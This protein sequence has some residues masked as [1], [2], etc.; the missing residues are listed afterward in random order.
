MRRRVR[1]RSL[2]AALALALAGAAA[3][4]G[5]HGD[6]ALRDP[7]ATSPGAARELVV[8]A[9]SELVHAGAGHTIQ[10][11]APSLVV[12][13]D[14]TPVLG[15]ARQDEGGRSVSVVRVEDAGFV[16]TR[17]DSAALPADAVH[18]PP[19]LALGTDG[20]LL[21]TWSAA[22]A[23]PEGVLFASDLE[24]SR[25][26]D[27]GRSFAPPLRVNDDRPISHSF[28]AVAALADGGALVAWI[29]SREGWEK[30]RTYVARFA[31]EGDALR[32][33]DER[34]LPGDTCVCC[35]VA[36]ASGAEG[37]VGLLWRD[38]FPGSVRDMVLAYAADG[39][40]R[41]GSR[42]R[43][44]EDA[45]S[46]EACPHRGGALAFDARGRAHVAWYTEGTDARPSVRYARRAA[47]GTFS[48]PLELAAGGESV[49]DHVALAATPDGRVVVVYEA[50]TAVRRWIVARA[51]ADGGA[52]FGPPQ[53]L[54]KAL[55]AY[56]PAVAAAP[57]GDFVVAWHEDAF[58]VRRSVVLRVAVP[59]R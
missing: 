55:K 7:R 24:L 19:G 1:A 51:S 2:G 32:R 11:S 36:A 48:E 40:G 50:V 41:F 20:A 18:Q 12:L 53:V 15:L 43:V 16:W 21:V 10:L 17:V 14:G 26:R 42:A 46:L 49:P 45:W 27:G 54:S 58:P 34:A 59:A 30:A 35:R 31:L 13:A 57:G 25:S 28:E 52:S 6:A 29:D 8:G 9:R 44:H 39:G 3:H 56:E 23:K 38:V 37:Q 4:A 5:A 22:K 47:D 33:Q